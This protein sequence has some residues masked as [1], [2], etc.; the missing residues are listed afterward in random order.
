MVLHSFD[1][2]FDEIEGFLLLA[3]MKALQ[4]GERVQTWIQKVLVERALLPPVSNFR[5]AVFDALVLL[6]LLRGYRRIVAALLHVSLDVPSQVVI[7][8]GLV[9]AGVIHDGRLRLRSTGRT[10]AGASV[11]YPT[12]FTARFLVYEACLS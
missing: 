2:H 9:R 12:S 1:I 8:V 7:D 6:S 11:T 3:S 10:T 5:V 4:L